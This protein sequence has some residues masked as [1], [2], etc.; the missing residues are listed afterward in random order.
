M[1]NKFKAYL[2]K[3]GKKQTHWA[4]ENKIAPSVISR[5]MHGKRISYDN[6][7]RIQRASKNAIKVDDILAPQFD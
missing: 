5:L 4:K 2:M 6:A 7:L 1:E 3:Q